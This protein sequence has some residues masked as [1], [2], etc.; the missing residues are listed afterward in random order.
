MTRRAILW[1]GHVKEPML[2][3]DEFGRL[4]EVGDPLA[5]TDDSKIQCNSLALAFQ[6]ALALG[7]PRQEVYACVIHEHLLP[8]GF[9]RRRHH[10][11]TVDG[12]RRLTR[13]LAARAAP[14]DALLFI[15]VNHCDREAL[16]TADPVDELD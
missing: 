3:R 14:E 2:A 8:E 11:A 13:A 7:V 12:L 6:A 1:C 9:D 5:A 10:P 15:A 16:A 4:S